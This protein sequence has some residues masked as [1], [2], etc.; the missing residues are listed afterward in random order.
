LRHKG[1][2]KAPAVVRNAL[3]VG[4]GDR[5]RWPLR[6][7]EAVVVPMRGAGH[8]DPA[9]DGLPASVERDVAA[10]RNID[11]LPTELLP[12]L[13]EAVRKVPVDLDEPLEGEV[14]LLPG[15]AVLRDGG[16]TLG[17]AQEPRPSSEPRLVSR[18]P[19]PRFEAPG[20]TWSPEP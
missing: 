1:Q 18:P 11:A 3:G 13:R 7:G 8:R 2:T 9:L 10:G 17:D 12:A 5:V 15:E 4:Y 14:S 20:A 19:S 16:F 6:G